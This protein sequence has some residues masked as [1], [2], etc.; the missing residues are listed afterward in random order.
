MFNPAV[1]MM[2][3]YVFAIL[4]SVATTQGWISE[5]TGGHISG[6]LEQVLGYGTAFAPALYAAA[7]VDNR[8][9]A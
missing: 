4:V 9:K 5:V 2:L 1:S 6:L 7:F 3:R 8:P